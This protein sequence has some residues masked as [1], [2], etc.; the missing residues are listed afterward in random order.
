MSSSSSS[1]SSSVLSCLFHCFLLLSYPLLS[2]AGFT[3]HGTRTDGGTGSGDRDGDHRPKVKRILVKKNTTTQ[4]KKVVPLTFGSPSS[5]YGPPPQPHKPTVTVSAARR[6]TY[7][8][9]SSY[10]HFE[11]PAVAPAILQH[12]PTSSY[13]APSSS[14]SSYNAPSSTY[15]VP[16]TEETS[17][18]PTRPRTPRIFAYPD[19]TFVMCLFKL[20]LPIPF[21]Q[22]PDSPCKKTFSLSSF[23]LDPVRFRPNLILL[24]LLSSSSPPPFFCQFLTKIWQRLA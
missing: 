23:L 6:P 20:A 18:A 10:V 15:H 7:F 13:H 22:S 21:C 16:A 5:S 3:A 9:N 14:S 8:S 11:P 24:R 1:S 19:G 2:A 12:L 17:P 4:E